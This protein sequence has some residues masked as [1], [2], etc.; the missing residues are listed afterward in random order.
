MALTY[1]TLMSL[2][3]KAPDFSLP[4]IDGKI[5]SLNSF[6]EAKALVVIF[7]CNHCP[8]VVAVQKRINDLA[9]FYQPKGIS[10]VGINSNDP[11]EYPEDGFEEMKV[12]AKEEG[13][14]F[15]YLQDQSQAI[16]KSYGAA[17][18]PDPY[19]FERVGSQFLLRYHGRIDDNWK[20][21]KE[22]TQKDLANALDSLL[23]GKQVLLDQK[24]AMGCSIKW[25]TVSYHR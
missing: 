22:V 8:Y 17:C 12:R 10:V 25:S 2:G 24:P 6:K 3:T 5:Y 11:I 13:Y 15:P 7:M 4:G 14:V 23:A 21:E 20:N 16:A 9:Q 18:T 19:V 1:S